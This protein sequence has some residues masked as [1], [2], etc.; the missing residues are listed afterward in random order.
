MPVSRRLCNA[1]VSA[2]PTLEDLVGSVDLVRERYLERYVPGQ[3]LYFREAS[4][5]LA[6]NAVWRQS[7][8]APSLGKR[9]E[10]THVETGSRGVKSPLDG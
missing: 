4:P 7:P 2:R 3:R 5:E 8:V 1:S 6:A 9:S 10:Y